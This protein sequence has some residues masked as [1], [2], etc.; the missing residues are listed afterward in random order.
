MD[1]DQPQSLDEH[2]GGEIVADSTDERRDVQ[3]GE[4]V[5]TE[6]PPQSRIS[7]RWDRQ[8]AEHDTRIDPPSFEASRQLDQSEDLPDAGS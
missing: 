7:D 1:L 3:H 4:L 8:T 5:Q 6:M 2:I